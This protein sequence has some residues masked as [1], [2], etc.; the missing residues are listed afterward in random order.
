MTKVRWATPADVVAFYG[1]ALKPTLQAVVIDVDGEIVGIGGLHDRDDKL[2]C[3]SDLKPQSQAHKK[4]IV[5]A[6]K[7]LLGLMHTKRRTIY[8]ICD[9]LIPSAPA[10]LSYL[11]FEPAGEY[12]Q[13]HP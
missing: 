5:R 12:Y 13:W 3:F 8:A 1:A 6:A 11:G 7:M 10:F 2:V 9:E 4:S